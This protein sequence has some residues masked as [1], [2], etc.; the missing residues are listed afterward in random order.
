MSADLPPILGLIDGIPASEL[1][2]GL[3][4][5][6]QAVVVTDPDGVV[7]W[8]SRDLEDAI[9]GRA[10]FGELGL[11]CICEGYLRAL[12]GDPGYEHH[13]RQ[14]HEPRHERFRNHHPIE[15]F[16]LKRPIA[17]ILEHLEHRESLFRYRIE[18]NTIE[19]RASD[20]RPSCAGATGTGLEINAF[21]V[22]S[23]IADGEKKRSP[24]VE[25]LYVTI[26]RPAP[27]QEAGASTH[28]EPGAFHKCVLDRLPEATL[29]IDTSGFI[30]YA[31]SAAVALLGTPSDPLID[32]PVSLYLPSSAIVEANAS[33]GSSP[34]RTNR[35]V[36]E[37]AP[38][39]QDPRFVEV[40][41]QTLELSDS[42]CAG[43]ILQLRDTTSEQNLIERLKQKVVSLE[44]YVH[45]VSH[46]LRSPLVSL[47]GFTRLMKSD[48]GEILGETGRRFLDR[49]EQAG[50]N[51][52]TLTQDLLELSTRKQPSTSSENVDPRNVLLRIQAEIKPRLEDRGIELRL[53]EAPPMVQCDRTQLYQIFSN[54]IG[55]ALQ[56]MG[57]CETPHIDI[58]IEAFPDRR[59][60][61][62]RDNGR[63][64]EASAHERIF[65]AFHSLS[66]GDD[67]PSTGV[68]LSI[69][70]KI[71][72]SHE[73][74]IWVESEPGKGAAFFV[75][76]KY[77]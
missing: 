64:I 23:R 19:G 56:H 70:K 25:R 73:G 51:M 29:T 22:D 55:N 34:G 69:V 49:I 17:E 16:D 63:G 48:F 61:V 42:T 72:L 38:S 15:A 40:A 43:R 45:T 14:N 62:V 26:L 46:D 3:A 50:S 74:R 71:A 2:D 77:R 54:L 57:P 60:I 10:R 7:L 30:T 13:E 76:L 32:T 21:R 28:S 37:F 39:G 58:E 5:L 66:R 36:V 11:A 6:H 12:N 68:G 67:G 53:P 47:L 33:H 18:P 8:A 41:S 52:N 59:V 4:S 24:Q 31:N 27:K 65:D 35:S 1:L 75:S 20:S 9:G 44:S